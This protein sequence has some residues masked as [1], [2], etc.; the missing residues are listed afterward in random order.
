MHLRQIYNAHHTIACI[1]LYP[2]QS[3][4]TGSLTT[5]SSGQSTTPISGRSCTKCLTFSEEFSDELLPN[6]FEMS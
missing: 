2:G 3:S 4:L 1:Y 6:V 5:G